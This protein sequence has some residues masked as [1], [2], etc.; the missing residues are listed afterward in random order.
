MAPAPTTDTASSAS[1]SQMF[2]GTGGKPPYAYL[3]EGSLTYSRPLGPTELGCLLPRGA[4]GYTDTFTIASLACSGGHTIT[5]DEVIH[6]CAALRLRHPLLASTIAFHPA[7]PPEFVYASPLTKAHALREARAQIEF[8]TFADQDAAAEAL[9]DQ[10]LSLDPEGALDLRY[11]TCSLYWARDVDPRAGRYIFGL[12][13]AH[14]VTDGRRKANIVRCML[15][16]LA[17]PG[18]AQRVLGAHFAGETPI[19]E[20]PPT[21]DSLLP[22]MSKADPA[23]LAKAKAAFD[24]FVK[25]RRRPL[26]GFVPDGDAAENNIQP[27][28]VRQTWSTEQTK[29]ILKACKAQGVTITHF[30]NAAS[31]FASVQCASRGAVPPGDSS[32]SGGSPEDCYYFDLCQAMDTNAKLPRLS[33]NGETETALRCTTYPIV[34]AVPRAAFASSTSDALWDA[35]RQYRARH[36]AY[37]DSPY[38]WYFAPFYGAIAAEN[39]MA[40]MAGGAFIPYVSSLGDMKSVLPARYPV[41]PSRAAVNGTASKTQVVSAEIRVLDQIQTGKAL[42]HSAAFLLYTFDDRL[43]LQFKWNAGHMSDGIMR[44]FFDRVVEIIS[45]VVDVDEEST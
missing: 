4:R 38:L 2:S 35:A 19:V 5:D 20:I 29:L 31:V 16:L 23:E 8:H 17:T 39:Y 44:S 6:A 1:P 36:E 32:G 43:N 10:W 30:A 37:V 21:L 3:R 11:G 9:R 7:Q 25:L 18:R 14:S 45:Q 26:F 42:P 24:E 27:R 28:F 41:Q 34:L 15:E 40:Q 33:S 12:M 22:D 13:M